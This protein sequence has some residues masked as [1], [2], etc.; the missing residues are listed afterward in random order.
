MWKKLT[1]KK[2]LPN[3]NQNDREAE[4]M[5]K[6][7]LPW[8]TLHIR[9]IPFFIK[10]INCFIVLFFCFFFLEQ[11]LCTSSKEADGDWENDILEMLKVH[12]VWFQ[13]LVVKIVNCAFFFFFFFFKRKKAES[14]KECLRKVNP[15]HPNISMH[16]LHTVFHAFFKVLTRRICLTIKSFSGWFSFALFLSP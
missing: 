9:Y 7:I 6:K 14:V 8:Y 2:K 13:R 1:E 5:K 3:N 4:L 10:C 11:L 15:L 12:Y 16:L